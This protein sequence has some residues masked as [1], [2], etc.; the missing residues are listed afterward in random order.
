[1]A[2]RTGRPLSGRRSR[3]TGKTARSPK[4]VGAGSA[5]E[6]CLAEQ[7]RLM[8]LPP[9]VRQAKLVP[10][11][12]FAFD[13]SWP[14][15]KLAVEVNGGTMMML[16]SHVGAGYERDCEK[17]AEALIAGYRVLHVT[18]AHVRRGQALTWI[19]KLLGPVSEH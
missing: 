7:I 16:P 4:R 2:S 3:G 6:D 1:M 18:S 8:Q 13:F 15:Q 14:R 12:R 19:V 11:R 17:A 10:G 9:P 5:L